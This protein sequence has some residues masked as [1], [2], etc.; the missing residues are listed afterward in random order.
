MKTF[1]P[2]SDLEKLDSHDHALPAEPGT[3]CITYIG[4]PTRFAIRFCTAGISA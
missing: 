3:T 1:K 2:L 4:L